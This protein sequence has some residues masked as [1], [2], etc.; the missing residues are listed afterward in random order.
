MR[1]LTSS[2]SSLTIVT[3]HYSNLIP[4]PTY[5][6]HTAYHTQC[7]NIFCKHRERKRTGI[8]YNYRQIVLIVGVMKDSHVW[9]LWGRHDRTVITRGRDMVTMV[10]QKKFS[11]QGVLVWGEDAT[12]VSGQEENTS[13]GH[14]DHGVPR[15]AWW[16]SS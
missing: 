2:E 3:Q 9:Q 16:P 14:N 11:H 7:I 12:R 5:T 6:K 8:G 10:S 4:L 1:L 13:W 15:V